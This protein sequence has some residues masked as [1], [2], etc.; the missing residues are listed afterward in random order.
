MKKITFLIYLISIVGYAQ[1]TT[2]PDPNFEQ[3][4]IDLGLDTAIDGQVLTAN[5]SEVTS[6]DVHSKNIT[7]LTGIADFTALVYLNCF[8]NQLTSLDVSGN[9]ALTYLFCS[10]N[11]LTSLDVSSNTALTYL[12]CSSNPLTSLDVSNNTVLTNLSCSSNQLTSLDI[13]NNTA[14]TVL[15][16]YYNELTSLDVSSNTALTYLYLHNNELTSL[17]VS[18]NPSLNELGC[19]DNQLTSLDVRNGNNA[20]I[21]YFQTIRNPNLNCILVDDADWSTTNW[22]VIDAT[23]TFVNNETECAALSIADNK[24]ELGVS[25]YP[26]PADNTLFIEGNENPIS[27]SIYNVLGK[28][29]ISTKNTN[30]IDVKALPSGVYIIRISDGARQTNRKFI[31]N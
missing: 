29:V 20:E 17:D 27:V 22:T 8:T 1:T 12:S 21:V 6:L 19:F 28:E 24:L 31:K 16:C 18:N 10:D 5:I 2:I 23:S 3:A 30:N 15:R 14:L 7:D 13:R 25:V 26:N 11:Q 4:L 9:T